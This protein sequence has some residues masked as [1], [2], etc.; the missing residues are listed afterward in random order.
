MGAQVSRQPPPSL[1]GGYTVGEQVYVTGTSQTFEDGDRVEHGKQ[2]EV[3]GPAA[4][5]SHKGKGVAVRFPGNKG[6]IQILLHE[7]RRRRRRRAQPTRSSPPPHLLLLP[8]HPR[9]VAR[10]RTG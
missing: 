10:G 2:G 7:V 3:A 1:P 9:C 8:A 5:E 4:A 6:L